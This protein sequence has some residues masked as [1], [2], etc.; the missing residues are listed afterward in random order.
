MRDVV[1]ATAT[2]TDPRTVIAN[3]VVGLLGGSAIGL[4]FFAAEAAVL[5]YANLRH[6]SPELR[7][8]VAILYTVV[9][10]LI[11]AAPALAG[12]RGGRWAL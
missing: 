5:G 7:V 6:G 8:P 11:G 1:Q 4:A 3:G 10:A 9:G 12:I 2:G